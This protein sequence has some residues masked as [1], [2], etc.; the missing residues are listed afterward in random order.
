MPTS[1]LFIFRPVEATST[2]LLRDAQQR[3]SIVVGKKAL[4][5]TQGLHLSIFNTKRNLSPREQRGMLHPV[6]KTAHDRSSSMR[7]ESLQITHPQDKLGWSAIALVLDDPEGLFRSEREVF[8]DRFREAKG[9]VP[10]YKEPHITLGLVETAMLTTDRESSIC[11]PDG[12]LFGPLNGSTVILNVIKSKPEI[13]PI[14][15][16]HD[17]PAWTGRPNPNP[18][19]GTVRR[20]GENGI[21]EGLLAA[22]RQRLGLDLQTQ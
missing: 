2:P 12:D 11:D 15:I 1:G 13:P 5:R 14:I 10:R 16:A 8:T 21:P 20:V 6:P 4:R 22:A 7:I 9:G 19:E 17:R 18:V 3:L